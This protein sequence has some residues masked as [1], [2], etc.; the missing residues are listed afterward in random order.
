[1]DIW[2][3]PIVEIRFDEFTRG[4]LPAYLDLHRSLLQPALKETLGDPMACYMTNVGRINCVTQLWSYESFEDFHRRRGAVEATAE[5][6]QYIAKAEGIVRFTNTRLTERI[7][8][9]GVDD[10]AEGVRMKPVIDFRTYR[11]HHNHMTTFLETTRDH[12]M[13]VMQRHI[14]PP[15]GYFLT[16]VGNLNEITHLWGFDSM[17]DMEVRRNARNADPEWPNYLEASNGIY[18]RQETQVLRRIDLA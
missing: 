13:Q 6:L 10:G 7:V 9:A 1:M 2:R 11:I 15:L 4:T 17:A 12:A 14:G 8:F 16:K 5:W 18:D 3:R